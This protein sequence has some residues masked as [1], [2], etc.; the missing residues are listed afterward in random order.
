[1]YPTIGLTCTSDVQQLWSDQLH[2]AGYSPRMLPLF[3]APA[4][5]FQAV[6]YVVEVQPGSA[7][8]K[9]GGWL[10]SLHAPL[11]LVTSRPAAAR[12]WAADLPHLALVVHPTHADHHLADLVS[13]ALHSAGPTLFLKPWFQVTSRVTRR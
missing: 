6:G 13:M 9:Y 12:G 11:I 2:Q 3:G 10:A 5:S 4:R 8:G 1:M 7:P